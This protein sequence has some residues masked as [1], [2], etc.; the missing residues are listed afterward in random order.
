MKQIIEGLKYL[1]NKNIK[2][3][4]LTWGNILINYDD[5]NDGEKKYNEGNNKN[6]LF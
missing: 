1:S 5:E 2:H 4:N 3:R 6:N